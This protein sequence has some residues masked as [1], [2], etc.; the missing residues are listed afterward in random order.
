MTLSAEN[1]LGPHSYS[2]RP[3]G[4]PRPRPPG[5][6]TTPT[7]ALV[8]STATCNFLPCTCSSVRGQHLCVHQMPRGPSDQASH[9]RN[10]EFQLT[11][12]GEG[13]Q[14]RGGGSKDRAGGE[15]KVATGSWGRLPAIR[16]EWVW[17]EVVR[18]GMTGSGGRQPARWA[19]G[20]QPGAPSTEKS[21]TRDTA[22][23]VKRLLRKQKT[24]VRIPAPV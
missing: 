3:P 22:Q 14:G 9:K 17:R 10:V 8:S 12:W 11:G 5:A 1:Q 20:G 4:A 21:N 6:Q 23:R 13:Q 15:D 18:M 2:H 7:A 16:A 24:Q 19:R